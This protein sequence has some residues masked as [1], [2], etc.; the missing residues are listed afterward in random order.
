MLVIQPPRVTVTQAV[1]YTMY[2]V[3]KAYLDGLIT[4]NVDSQINTANQMIINDGLA[5]ATFTVAS[6]SSSSEQVALQTTAVVGPDIHVSNIKKEIAG[7]KS[8]DVQTII[9]QIPGVTSVNVHLSPFWVGSVPT[10]PNK[11]TITIGKAS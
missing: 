2:G 1:T 3:K 10:N 6:T 9:S 4:N 7:K 8:G 5:N 11:V